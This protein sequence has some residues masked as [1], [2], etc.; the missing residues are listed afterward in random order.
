MQDSTVNQYEMRDPRDAYP[1][2][3]F[4]R[5]PQEAPGLATKMDPEPDHGEKSY[6]GLSRMKG[7]KALIT[8]GDSGIGRATAIAYMREG[9]SVVIN[10]LETEQRDV[11]S[12]LDLAKAE[13]GTIIPMPGNLMDEQFCTSLVK[14]AAEQMGGLDVLVINAGKQVMQQSIQDI[15]TEQFDQTLKTNCYA[16]FWLCKAALPLM[17]PGA[18]IIN[19]TSVVGYNPMPALLDYSSTK[20]FIRGFTQ[21]L[22]QQALKQGVRVNAVAPGPFW[23]PLQS[24]GGQTQDNLEEFGS[25]FPMGRPG[26]PAEIAPTFVFLA[27]QESGYV[28]GEVI[29]VTGGMPTS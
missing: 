5:Q 27:T 13:G 17:P 28:A 9:A 23:T 25:S 3:P 10:Y 6:Q 1:Q 29:G 22:A 12:L 20:F 15:T 4:P 8:G 21:A 2:P 26:Q 14:D 7:R 11:D 18:A 16:M 24:S 19:V